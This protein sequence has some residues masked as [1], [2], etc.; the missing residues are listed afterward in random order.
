M[1]RERLGRV[2]EFPLFLWFSSDDTTKR[3]RHQLTFPF[4]VVVH[5]EH[6]LFT[7]LIRRTIAPRDYTYRAICRPQNPYPH[8]S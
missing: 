1:E 4:H 7:S 6:I 8:I 3:D 2:R 5:Y